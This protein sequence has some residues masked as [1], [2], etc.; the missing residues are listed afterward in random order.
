MS[1]AARLTMNKSELPGPGMYDS[2][3]QFSFAK[4]KSP[5]F[6][7]GTSKRDTGIGKADD[8]PGPGNYN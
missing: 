5:N 2:H 7:F 8:K 6:G 4:A 3:A 1:K